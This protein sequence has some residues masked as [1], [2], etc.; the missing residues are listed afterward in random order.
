MS[1]CSSRAYYF[2]EI[3]AYALRLHLCSY[4]L[5][6]RS[7]EEGPDERNA[8][9]FFSV[10]QDYKNWV[11]WEWWTCGSTKACPECEHSTTSLLISFNHVADVYLLLGMKSC[12]CALQ[13]GCEPVVWQVLTH[14][15]HF[16]DPEMAHKWWNSIISVP[17]F[18]LVEGSIQ[19]KILS[20]SM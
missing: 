8:Y 1:Y 15:F 9:H 7:G 3:F 17:A 5:N 6:F 13:R 12:T 10:Y 2:F 20:H 19:F 11:V 18:F 14:C 4:T 16:E